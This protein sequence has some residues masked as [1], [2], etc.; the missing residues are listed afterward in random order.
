MQADQKRLC[1]EEPLSRMKFSLGV[2]R[3]N[4]VLSFQE[5]CAL[6]E[7]SEK[8][9]LPS[10]GRVESHLPGFMGSLGRYLVLGCEIYS[11]ESMK[12]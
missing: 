8:I 1:G 9:S 11:P 7:A 10:F 5:L 4:K 6:T 12:L 2:R 3:N